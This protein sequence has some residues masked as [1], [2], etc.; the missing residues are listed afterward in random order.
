MW[1]FVIPIRIFIFMVAVNACTET[2]ELIQS[3]SLETK[4]LDIPLFK[5]LFYYCE[6]NSIE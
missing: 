1:L 4:L 6:A 2:N 3:L 5:R